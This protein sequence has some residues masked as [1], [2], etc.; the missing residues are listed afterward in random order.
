MALKFQD[1]PYLIKT[2]RLFYPHEIINISS[3]KSPLGR[4]IKTKAVEFPTYFTVF[5]S[6]TRRTQTA[7]LFVCKSGLADG[8]VV[9]MILITSTLKRN[10]K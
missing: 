2:H 3:K 9:A 4:C 7:I 8:T 10:A 1:V 5:A 6:E